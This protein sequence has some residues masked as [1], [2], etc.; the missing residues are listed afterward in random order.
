MPEVW[1]THRF[2]RHERAGADDRRADEQAL[3][4]LSDARRDARDRPLLRQRPCRIDE[5]LPNATS[6]SR[7]CMLIGF[8]VFLVARIGAVWH[9]G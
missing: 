7:Y 4:S 8:R 6:P 2:V 5:G 1:R 3:E 9:H